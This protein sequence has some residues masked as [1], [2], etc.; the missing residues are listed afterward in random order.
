MYEV[1]IREKTL[2]VLVSAPPLELELEL[3]WLTRTAE[4]RIAQTRLLF[5]LQELGCREE[6][7]IRFRTRFFR[8]TP[9]RS[10]WL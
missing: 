10:G 8:E 4:L 5:A 1:I 3:E 6:A 9:R 2:A 7:F